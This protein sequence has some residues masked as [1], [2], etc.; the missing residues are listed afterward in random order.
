VKDLTCPQPIFLRNHERNKYFPLKYLERS[1]LKTTM[2][3]SS[4][5]FESEA[6][7]S[8]GTSKDGFPSST[9]T[10]SLLPS[11]PLD[12]SYFWKTFT[13]FLAVDV[14]IWIFVRRYVYPKN[15]KERFKHEFSSWIKDAYEHQ[16][17]RTANSNWNSQSR[18]SQSI[19]FDHP[20]SRV[21]DKHLDTL[22]LSKRVG[23]VPKE[24]EIKDAY[25]KICLKTHPDVLGSDHPDK[26]IAERKFIEATSS[27]NFLLEYLRK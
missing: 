3:K 20:S 4:S 23:I 14:L 26:Q 2:A 25:R 24:A 11:V 27:Y 16:T 17:E 19:K 18:T 7:Q 10:S 5:N 1:K 15:A 8:S 13:I 21:I 6:L 22:G 12:R 9:S